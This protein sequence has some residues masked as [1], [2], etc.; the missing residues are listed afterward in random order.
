MEQIIQTMERMYRLTHAPMTLL[1]ED[2][3]LLATFPAAMPSELISQEASATPLVDFR[4]QK[5]DMQHPLISFI[6]PGYLLGVMQIRPEL[7]VMIGLVSPYPRSKNDVL[8]MGVVAVSPEH[9]QHF[10]SIMQQLPLMSL[11]QVRDL[12][13]LLSA[14]LCE[15]PVQEKDILFVDNAG[16]GASSLSTLDHAIFSQREEAQFHVSSEYETELCDAIA[17]GNR[18]Q[19]ERRLLSPVQGRVGKMSTDEL[20]QEKYSF[21]CLATL[22]S[23]AAIRGGL[24]EETAYNLSDI[25]CQ[26]ADLKTDVSSVQQLVFSMLSDLCDH[27]RECHEQP[28]SSPVVRRALRYISVHLHE[29]IVLEQLSEYCNLCSRSLSRRFRAEVG[30]SIPDYIHREKVKEA[31][32]LLRYTD[33]TLSEISGFLNYPSQSYFTRIFKKELELT[34]QQYRDRVK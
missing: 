13:L 31:E 26:R 34:P 2:G 7:F 4:L 22:A 18:E 25:Y 15:E 10:C 29:T 9:L 21:V 5:R 20:R 11:E 33:L 30:L 12:M 3:V 14:F 24:P 8:R 1:N 23:R 16:I 32:Y 6:E 28:D 17:A 27:V 19:L